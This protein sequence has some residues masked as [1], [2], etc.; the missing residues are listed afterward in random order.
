MTVMNLYR[1]AVIMSN[2]IDLSAHTWIEGRKLYTRS[3]EVARPWPRREEVGTV[4]TWLEDKRCWC[5]PL[6]DVA[7]VYEY[8]EGEPWARA[9][10]QMIICGP[11]DAMPLPRTWAGEVVLH[12]RAAAVCDGAEQFRALHAALKEARG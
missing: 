11:T 10:I 8:H 6:T 12:R 7:P 1:R 4:V 2:R 3:D 9:D 5:I